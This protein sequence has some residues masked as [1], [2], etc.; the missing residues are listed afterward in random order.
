MVRLV[1]F[2]GTTFAANTS[3][4]KSW[5]WL[6]DRTNPKDNLDSVLF[7]GNVN[8]GTGVER[9]Q[10]K[11]YNSHDGTSWQKVRIRSWSGTTTGVVR[12]SCSVTADV[13]GPVCVAQ[14]TL[15]EYVRIFVKNSGAN[16]ATLTRMGYGR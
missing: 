2:S 13:T 5:Q 14:D 12:N 1:A 4:V 9:M 7:W 11:V 16:P 15:A 3:Q 6:G 10:F 8:V